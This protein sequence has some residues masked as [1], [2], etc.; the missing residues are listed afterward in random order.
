MAKTYPGS[1]PP[2]ADSGV[3]E[4]G[5]GPSP[6]GFLRFGLALG[7]VLTFLLCLGS[8]IVW[9][10][11]GSPTFGSIPT[12]LVAIGATVSL[13]CA[14]VVV[15]SGWVW[16]LAVLLG[17]AVALPTIAGVVH[18]YRGT[19]WV[20]AAMGLAVAATVCT[21]FTFEPSKVRT[22]VFVALAAVVWLSLI[23]GVL[24]NAGVDVNGLYT[25]NNREFFGLYQ[26]AGI[27]N[28]PN[29]LGPLAGL[30]L[31]LQSLA[32]PDFRDRPGVLVLALFLGPVASATAL[33]WTQSKSGAFETALALFLVLIAGF[34]RHRVVFVAVVVSLTWIAG[35]FLPVIGRADPATVTPENPPFLKDTLTGRW[36]PWFVAEQEFSSNELLGVGPFAFSKRFWKQYPGDS[37]WEPSHAHNQI[38]EAMV[39]LGLV[40]LVLLVAALFV[41]SLTA[42]RV[43]FADRGWLVAV[44]GVTF[45]GMAVEVVLGVNAASATFLLPLLLATVAGCAWRMHLQEIPRISRR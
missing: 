26:L 17:V 33:F 38:W 23:F 35:A 19:D 32:L 15:R 10:A 41:V 11:N 31:L 28:H 13:L 4:T 24:A 43:R 20:P 29:I 18:D 6:R 34:L 27:A 5:A 22:A 42:A 14:L 1:Q 12:V 45:S 9:G 7:P 21:A 40:G 3:S 37:Y 16:L 39:L 30:A 8:M 25:N 2:R 44:A 36:F